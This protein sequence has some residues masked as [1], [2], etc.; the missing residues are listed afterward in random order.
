LNIPREPRVDAIMTLTSGNR[1]IM[2]AQDLQKVTIPALLVHGKIDAN[3]VMGVSVEVFDTIASQ[4]KALV[5]LERA[6]HGAFSIQRCAQMQATGAIAMA[7]PRAIGEQLYFE[8]IILSGNSGTPIDF[9][10]FD[11]FVNPVDIRPLV[12]TMTGIDVTPDNVPRDLDTVAAMRLV[13]ELANTF[14]DATLVKNAQ[15]GVH[16]KQ[17]MSPKFLFLKEGDPVSY[18]ESWSFQGRPVECDDPDLVSLDPAC[19][20]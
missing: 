4:E 9:C 19:V 16:F 12:K 20:E 15:P 13:L 7:N 8:N 17:Y 14:F 6:E 18:A 10:L 11:S 5:I 1:A 3:Q 2:F